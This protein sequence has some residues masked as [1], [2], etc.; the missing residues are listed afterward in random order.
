MIAF[1]DGWDPNKDIEVFINKLKDVLGEKSFDHF[2][3][4]ENS[5][6]FHESVSLSDITQLI[7][8]NLYQKDYEVINITVNKNENNSLDVSLDFIK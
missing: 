1:R 5:S 4:H 3:L 2:E 8:D 7:Y 6:S